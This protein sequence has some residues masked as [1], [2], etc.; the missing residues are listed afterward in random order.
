MVASAGPCEGFA[1][2]LLLLLLLLLLLV[3][4]CLSERGHLARRELVRPLR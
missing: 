1:L 4:V 3:W 2:T